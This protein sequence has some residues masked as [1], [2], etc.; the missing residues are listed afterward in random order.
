M[1]SLPNADLSV[2]DNQ[3]TD[4][5]NDYV[6]SYSKRI[7]RDTTSRG[8]Q[9]QGDEDNYTREHNKSHDLPHNLPT[10]QNDDSERTKAKAPTQDPVPMNA[11]ETTRPRRAINPPIS[12]VP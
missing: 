3:S 6:P 10:H 2:A 12:Y 8:V 1:Y 9:D 11:G 5:D 7:S 4:E